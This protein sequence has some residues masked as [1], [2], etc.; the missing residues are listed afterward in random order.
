MND[1]R[2]LTF[3]EEASFLAARAIAHATAYLDGRNDTAE[4]ARHVDGL[5]CELM[6]VWSATSDLHINAIL[7]PVR[8][9]VVAMRHAASAHGEARQDR[10]HQVMGSLVELVRQESRELR[11][12]GEQQS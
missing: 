6:T 4:L 2:L 9:L 12:A 1:A 3:A 8:L 7:N 10:W 5:Q 11:E